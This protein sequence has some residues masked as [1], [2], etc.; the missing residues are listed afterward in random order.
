MENNEQ[1]CMQYWINWS[2]RRDV[3]SGVH[4]PMKSKYR[5]HAFDIKYCNA[6]LVFIHILIRFWSAFVASWIYWN[7]LNDLDCSFIMIYH[8]QKIITRES[9]F[10]REKL[11]WQIDVSANNTATT[12]KRI[13]FF[14]I[15]ITK[16]IRYREDT[17]TYYTYMSGLNNILLNSVM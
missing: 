15:D 6:S 2:Q 3:G 12:G 1:P 7:M 16:S 17:F 5:L 10:R 4:H 13:L 9:I 11:R 8:S 14:N